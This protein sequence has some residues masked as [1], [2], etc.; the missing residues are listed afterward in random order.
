MQLTLNSIHIVMKKISAYFLFVIFV[1]TMSSCRKDPGGIFYAEPEPVFSASA[2]FG[3]SDVL[4]EAGR[5]DFYMFTSYDDTDSLNVLVFEGELKK[6]DAC[7][8]D[9]DE[10]LS[11]SIRDS[12]VFDPAVSTVIDITEFQDID[13]GF[14][15]TE[16]G[17]DVISAYEITFTDQSFS[18]EGSGSETIWSYL[19]LDN[20]SGT[21]FSDTFAPTALADGVAVTL[22]KY[23]GGNFGC[24][25]TYEKVIDL[26]FQ[27][28]CFLDV[29]FNV[30]PNSDGVNYS[31]IPYNSDFPDW[32]SSWDVSNFSD[33]LII[34][35]PGT[36][37]VVVSN[38]YGCTA[39]RCISISN[40]SQNIDSI[41]Y[42]Y[43]AFS[44]E[45][46]PFENQSQ[47][48]RFDFSKI[49]ITY[50]SKDGIEYRSDRFS[51]PESSFFTIESLESY[52]INEFQQATAK[53]DAKFQ[54]VLYSE[55]GDGVLMDQ[56]EATIGVAI[57]EF[58]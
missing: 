42:C 58:K 46:T 2:K 3:I 16:I 5:D 38:A 43:A 35:S 30:V 10:S 13:F 41:A 51:Q 1:L 57:P 54:V 29:N 56:G 21:Q 44:Y 45:I 15:G 14:V 33:T 17:E 26:D 52:S 7:L 37:C 11:F 22:E 32:T 25:S 19:S 53:L 50:V 36:Y 20:I 34:D 55:A 40:L 47:S 18:T 12:R 48:D 49:L 8:L 31:V 27:T 9:C 24:N 28:D 6:L 39:E 4:I 23:Y